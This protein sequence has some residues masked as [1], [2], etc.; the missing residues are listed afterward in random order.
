MRKGLIISIN[1][2]LVVIFVVHTFRQSNDVLNLQKQK[3]QIE[4]NYEKLRSDYEE[5]SQQIEECKT[6]NEELAQQLDEQKRITPEGY[7]PYQGYWLAKSWYGADAEGEQ[8]CC[9]EIVIRPNFII[10]SGH[11]H[12]T[13]EPIYDIAV[14]IWG[15]V[16]DEL[17]S[18]GV[19]DENLIDM[20]Q[21]ECY[22]E[23]DISNTYN[24]HRELFP[25]EVDFV[26]NAKYYIID[27][28]TMLCVSKNNGGRVYVLGRLGY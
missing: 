21:A 12:V 4:K 11:N 19:E 22:A 17:K 13:D 6:V 27:N 5:L 20:L 7:Q 14:R 25:R 26:E 9:M 24:W 2:I 15:D 8:E 1:F 28:Q 23:L 18:I 10:L 3:E 16:I